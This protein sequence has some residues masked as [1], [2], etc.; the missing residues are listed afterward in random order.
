MN[1]KYQDVIYVNS[2]SIKTDL[3]KI[4]KKSRNISTK[5]EEKENNLHI[6]EIYEISYSYGEN[7]L[8]LIQNKL[9]ILFKNICLSPKRYNIRVFSNNSCYI[10]LNTN[11]ESYKTLENN[12]IIL[13]NLMIDHI[14]AEYKDDPML[15]IDYINNLRTKKTQLQMMHGGKLCHVIFIELKINNYINTE[16]KTIDS[17]SSLLKDFRFNNEKTKSYYLADFIVKF[18]CSVYQ[19]KELKEKNKFISFVPYL[20]RIELRSNKINKDN[21]SN[22]QNSIINTNT[23]IVM[24]DNILVL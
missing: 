4:N 12:I 17:F 20:Q 1:T 9:A 3:I 13:R 16:I 14:L 7:P 10:P 21:I 15:N 18:K 8:N 19:K 22:I 11:H 5:Y 24:L 23:K 2:Q 6:H